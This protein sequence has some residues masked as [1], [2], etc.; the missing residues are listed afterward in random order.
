M[1]VPIK[2]EAL[3]AL[4]YQ[5]AVAK[6]PKLIYKKHQNIGLVLLNVLPKRWQ[7]AVIKFLLGRNIFA[8]DPAPRG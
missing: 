8:H 3:A 7:C 5:A 1:G 6:R 4:I 2:P